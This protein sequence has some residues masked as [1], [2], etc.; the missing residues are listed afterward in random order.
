MKKFL[1]MVLMLPLITLANDSTSVISEITNVD[2]TQAERI[3]DKY[4]GKIVE[5]F[6]NFAEK[7]TPYA[8][9][10]FKV[11]VK[12]QIAKG[13]AGLIPPVT[14]IILLILIFKFNK[15]AVW[16]NHDSPINLYAIVQLIFG[17]LAA[18]MFII[19]LFSTYN[20]ILHLIAPEWYAIKEIIDLLK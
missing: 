20:A 2:E 16:D 14:C 6:N 5:G 1:F 17:I 11:V 8:E 4:G 9:E 7:A 18:I 13:I 3:I 15:K 10:G 12:L 19:A